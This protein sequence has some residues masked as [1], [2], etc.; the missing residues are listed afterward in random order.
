MR[1]G[2][3]EC[4][5]AVVGGSEDEQ[6]GLECAATLTYGRIGM[7]RC[8]KIQW[9]W[10]VIVGLSISLYLPTRIDAQ[11]DAAR[12]AL[13]KE[14]EEYCARTAST[15][16]THDMIMQKVS[17]GCDLI[18]KEGTAAFPKFKGKHSPFL[19]AGTYIWIHDMSA[20]MKM[21]PT[22][23]DM[24][25]Q[26]LLG[27]KDVNGKLFFTEMNQCAK[28]R[29]SCWIDYMWP[30]PG[31]TEPSHKASYVKLCRTPEGEKLVLGCGSYDLSDHEIK[32]LVENP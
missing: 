16:V 25:G 7:I 3:G 19:F 21:H 24:E 10:I 5:E 32:M 13:A 17:E 15:K 30:K 26:T 1:K 11:D 23:W 18:E 14:S 8:S 27:V 29:G 6:Q 9:I 20:V 22:K 12:E 4:G 31:E 28:T 2:R